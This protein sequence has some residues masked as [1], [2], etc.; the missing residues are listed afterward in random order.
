MPLSERCAGTVAAC[1]IDASG[2]PILPSRRAVLDGLE[3]T[4]LDPLS[5][6]FRFF[7]HGGGNLVLVSGFTQPPSPPLQEPTIWALKLASLAQSSLMTLR[8]RC[9][10]RGR[11]QHSCG[12]PW[13]TPGFRASVLPFVVLLS[14]PTTG[15][16]SA[17]CAD[18]VQPNCSGSRAWNGVGWLCYCRLAGARLGAR[19]RLR[20]RCTQHRRLPRSFPDQ[21][22]EIGVA[23]SACQCTFVPDG[24]HAGFRPTFIRLS[25]RTFGGRQESKH[26]SGLSIGGQPAAEAALRERGGRRHAVRSGQRGS[27]RLP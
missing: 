14:V 25:R 20:L 10:P 22:G 4:A 3:G 15:V 19:H 7:T 2:G 12:R 23:Q 13:R 17:H 8:R 26:R 9:A 16:G 6:D 21:Q 1:S 24:G 18:E 5:A 27:I 11:V